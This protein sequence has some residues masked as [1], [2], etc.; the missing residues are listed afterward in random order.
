MA[1]IADS[2]L[3]AGLI[4]IRT[5]A[6]VLHICSAEPSNLAAV[7]GLT[8]GIKDNPVISTPDDRPGGGRQVTVSAITDGAAT[9]TGQAGHYALVS[10]TELLAAGPLVAQIAVASGGQFT[11]TAFPVGIPDA[12]PSA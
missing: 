4:H 10:T 5:N 2:V 12:V 7:S 1:Y 3:D 9:S 6:T 11:L 8:L